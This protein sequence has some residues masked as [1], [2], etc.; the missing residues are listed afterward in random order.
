MSHEGAMAKPK[1][2]KPDPFVTLTMAEILMDQGRWAQAL[3]IARRVHERAPDDP[4]AAYLVS[5]LDPI[6]S[7]RM[8]AAQAGPDETPASG[9]RL[10]LGDHGGSLLWRLDEPSLASSSRSRAGAGSRLAARLFWVSK[11]ARGPTRRT[12]DLFIDGPSGRLELGPL[13]RNRT[14]GAAVGWLG[15]RGAF[16]A[17]AHAFMEGER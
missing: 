8:E 3:E 14:Y 17:V 13:P 5:F 12:K 6:V 7:S 1:P 10:V 15:A 11:G 9:V 4:S 2:R 16:I